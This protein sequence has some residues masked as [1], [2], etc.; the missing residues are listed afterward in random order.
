MAGVAESDMGAWRGGCRHLL[1]QTPAGQKLGP[2]VLA[3]DLPEPPRGEADSRQLASCAFPRP[4]LVGRK[5]FCHKQG[6][7]LN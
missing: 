1:N 7:H 6:L 4:F 3:K 5:Q 2:Q